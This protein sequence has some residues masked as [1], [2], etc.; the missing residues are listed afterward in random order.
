MADSL[1]ID[2]ML[3]YKLLSKLSGVF[4]SITHVNLENL[5]SGMDLDIWKHAKQNNSAILTKDTD[6]KNLSNLFGCPPKVV[7]INCGNKT[8]DF[9]SNL[10][11]SKPEIIKSFLADDTDCYLEIT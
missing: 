10:L 3:S 6:F 1:I 4:P 8:T 5:K 2:E 9:I 7:H 11:L